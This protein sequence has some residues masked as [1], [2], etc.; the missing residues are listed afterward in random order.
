MRIDIRR[1]R[2]QDL[3]PGWPVHF[4]HGLLG[5]PQ[6]QAYS[7]QYPIQEAP[8]RWLQAM[9]DP[10]LAFVIV[11]P[12]LVLPDYQLEVS[13]QDMQELGGV[14]P[15]SLLVCAIV[16]LPREASPGLTVN[17][18]GPILMNGM[19]GWAKQLVLMDSPYHTCHPLLVMHHTP[20]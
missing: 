2:L 6:R 10:P 5:F 8:F 14:D 11:D 13:E 3:T 4:P 19:N 9:G 12:F 1:Q 7:I 16:T 18:Q 20:S 17:L 15:D